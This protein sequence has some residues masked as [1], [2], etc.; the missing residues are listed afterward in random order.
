MM[1]YNV[2]LDVVSGETG[3]A[4]QYS[5]CGDVD[6]LI[7]HDKERELEFIKGGQGL[8]DKAHCIQLSQLRT[9]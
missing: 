6:V 3:I 2:S 5:E 7:V 1:K 8:E 4:I 9:V